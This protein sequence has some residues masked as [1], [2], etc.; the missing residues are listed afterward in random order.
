MDIGVI[1]GGSWGT[2]QAKLLAENGHQVTLWCH[3]SWLPEE[4]NETREN[5]EFLPGYTLPD[6]LRATNDLEASVDGRD[7]ILSVMPS[8]VVRDVMT[9]IADSLP[10]GVPIVSATKG[11]EN[12]TLMLVS[13][14]LEDVLPSRLH[15]YLAYLSGPSFAVEVADRQPTAVTVASYNH[16]LAEKVQQTFSNDYFRVYTSTDVIGVEVGGAAKNVIAIAAGA[17]SGMGLG[18]NAMAGVITRGL[19]EISRL[20][21]NLGANP[22]TLKGLSGM[23]DLVL[24]CTSGLSRNHTVGTKLGE[25][26]SLDEILDDMNMVAEG[27]KTSKSVHDLAHDLD[28]EMPISQEVY[29]VLYQDKSAEKAVQDLMGRELKPEIRGY[30]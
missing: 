20:A 4:I 15:P 27:V 16:R 11:I 8:H 12:D 18:H 26:H 22:L 10:T 17:A 6:S 24:T 5:S 1:G 14:I 29:R 21:V 13:D 3:E 19:H 9:Q 7:M 30:Y 25:G 28:V 2:A 23:G